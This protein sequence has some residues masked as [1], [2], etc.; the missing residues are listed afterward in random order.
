MSKKI[1]IISYN[2]APRHTVGAIR[3]TKLAQ[4][5]AEA[6]NAVDVVTVKPFGDLDR[7]MDCVFDHVGK[8]FEIDRPIIRESAPAANGTKPAPGKTD[9]PSKTKKSLIKK[10]KYQAYE[11]RRISGSRAFARE[12]KKLVKSDPERF[13][14]YDAVISSYGP[15][16]S[17]LCGLVMKKLCPGVRW[18]ADFR[19]P[20]AVSTTTLL[21]RRARL[22]IQRKVCRNADRLVAVSEGY[23]ERIFDAD[24]QKKA[25]VIYNGYDERDVDRSAVEPDGEFSFT[26][27]GA[28]YDGMRDISPLFEALASLVRDGVIE[29]GDIRF[30]YAGGAFGTLVGQAEKSGLADRLFDLG[31]LSRDDCLKLQASSRH[32]VLATWNEGEERGVF[33]GKFIEYI[34]AKRPV[35][36]LVSGKLGSSEVTRVM[37]RGRLGATYEDATRDRDLRSLADYLANDYRLY[38]NGLPPAF[39]PDEKTVASFDFKETAKQFEKLISI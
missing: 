4:Y 28:L 36:S 23:Y 5:L 2:F 39:D 21:T 25:S 7:S 37:E 38:K 13:R 17:H 34:M 32:L 1:L 16:A 6:G 15:V 35:I 29:R 33:P 20:M 22:S 26:Y 10:L 3:P 31:R 12:F 11:Y 14:S 30:K 24:A 19:D 9:K 27:V 18:I 8:V